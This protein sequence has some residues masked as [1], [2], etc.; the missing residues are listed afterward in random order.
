MIL[1]V[2]IGFIIPVREVRM[3][4]GAGFITPI[5]GVSIIVFQMFPQLAHPAHMTISELTGHA[6]DAWTGNTSWLL[7]SQFR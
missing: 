2:P 4:A 3:S 6:N 1:G 5:L 7:G